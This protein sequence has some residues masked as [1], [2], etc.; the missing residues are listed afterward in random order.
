[1]LQPLF[2][3]EADHI[4]GLNLPFIKPDARAILLQSLSQL[5]HHRLIFRA[6][7]DEHIVFERLLIS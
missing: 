2:D 1:M 3:L 4:V 6:M 5:T 7:A